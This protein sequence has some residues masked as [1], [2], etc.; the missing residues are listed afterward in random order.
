MDVRGIRTEA[1][2]ASRRRAL[3][4]PRADDSPPRNRLLA[5]LPKDDFDRL[6]PHLRQGP[7]R[8]KMVLQKTGEPIE[9]VY[10][11]NGGAFSLLSTL[12]TGE[13]V[14]AATVGDE[15]VLGTEAFFGDHPVSIADSVIQVPDTSV[16]MLPATVFRD[17][18]DH[19]GPLFTV[20]T[21][22]LQYF[23]A[24][25]VH[26]N[27]C[28]VTHKVQQRCARWL[29]TTAHR[30]HQDTF[31]LSHE[32][33]ATML[34]VQRPTVTEVAGALQAARLIRYRHGHIEIVDRKGL[35]RASCECYGVIRTHFDALARRLSPA[36]RL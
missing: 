16:T 26:G 3:P 8:R 35:E 13:T 36:P 27:T 30:V 7:V 25:L 20:I 12:S 31:Q 1:N 10:F 4:A 14:Q 21:A 33:L 29:L 24:Q 28:N 22:Y 18:L 23:V 17:E 9:H 15:G 34:G 11:P 2:A 19:R 6:E 5:A 32:F